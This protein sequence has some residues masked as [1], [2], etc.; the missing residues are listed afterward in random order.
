MVG[1]IGMSY[2]CQN[3]SVCCGTSVKSKIRVWFNEDIDIDGEW[4][5]YIDLCIDC[6]NPLS[7]Y[8]CIK[9]YIA[10]GLYIIR[11]APL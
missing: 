1:I 7:Q 8:N 11:T 6:Y 10:E 3:C 9:Q 4:N 2:C 5:K